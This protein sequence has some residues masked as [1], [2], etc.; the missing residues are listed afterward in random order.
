MVISQARTS[1]GLG[2]LPRLS[3]CDCAGT[4]GPTASTITNRSR[5]REPIF[6]RP[7][8]AQ[9]PRHDEI[10][11]CF[12]PRLRLPKFVE[13]G[14]RRLYLAL[15]IRATG[16][17]HML[18][19][20]PIPGHAEARMRDTMYCGSNFGILPGLASVCGYF[21]LANGTATGPG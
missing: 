7:V 8:T 11:M 5:L 13:L 3:E 18:F 6:N 4:A 19:S 1:S 9:L 12:A 14:H 17:Q 21:N 16:H 15:L 10:G 2:V 20:A